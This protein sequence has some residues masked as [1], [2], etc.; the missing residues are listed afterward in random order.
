MKPTRDID[1]LERGE[2][3]RVG[4]YAWTGERLAVGPG[5]LLHLESATLANAALVGV[6]KAAGIK[7]HRLDA[8]CPRAAE[9]ALC[10]RGIRQ[11]HRADPTVRPRLTQDPRTGVVAVMAIGEVFDELAFGL[12]AAAAVLIDHHVAVA[13]EECSDIGARLRFLFRRRALGPARG[14][15]VVRRTL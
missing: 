15:L 9:C 5:G 3:L 13:H 14:S 12:V 1:G 4:V 2:R 10:V 11:T 6:R 8:R 7:E